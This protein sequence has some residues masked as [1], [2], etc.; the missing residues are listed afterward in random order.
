MLLIVQVPGTLRRFDFWSA[1]YCLHFKR[2]EIRTRFGWLAGFTLKM[3]A[4]QSFATT[5]NL[6][7]KKV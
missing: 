1:R 5:V 4:L 7:V 2:V 6:P 3:K